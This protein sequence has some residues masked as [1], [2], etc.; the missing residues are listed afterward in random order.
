MPF[1]T[2]QQVRVRN[3]QSRN[4]SA[5]QQQAAIGSTQH[6]VSSARART[7][8]HVS[9]AIFKLRA[10]KTYLFIF[11]KSQ[12]FDRQNV[13]VLIV[14]VYVCVCLSDPSPDPVS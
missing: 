1:Y 6:Q 5:A 11:C 10:G 14:C 12:C 9:S 7:V 8:H 4:E 13:Y 3:A 2:A